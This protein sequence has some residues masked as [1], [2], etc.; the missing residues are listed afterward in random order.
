MKTMARQK[1]LLTGS[2][3]QLG[4]ELLASCPE[5]VELIV[6]SRANL[7]LSDAESCKS[8]V[9]QYRPDWVLNAGAYTAVDRAESEPELA[10]AVNADA[11]RAFAE[12]LRET[13]GKLLQLSTD[14]VFSGKQSYP[15]TPTQIAEPI[16]M[17]GSSKAAGEAAVVS[18]LLPEQYSILR[19]SWVYGPVGKNFCLTMLRLHESRAANREELAVVADQIG[20]PTSTHGLAKACWAAIQSQIS[21]ILHWS[22]AGAASWYDFAEAIG[23][24]GVA[25]GLLNKAAMVQPISTED[26]PTPASR[27][28][29]SLLNCYSSCKLLGLRQKHWRTALEEVMRRIQAPP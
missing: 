9:L 5:G 3:G 10:Y 12:A 15:Y 26:Y 14:F 7:D 8:A 23:E 19:T 22:D 16:S 27:P 11:P 21:G 24:I 2:Q 29:Y 6:T 20:S 13:G 4:H 28:S 17:Y 18:I 1:V 25:T